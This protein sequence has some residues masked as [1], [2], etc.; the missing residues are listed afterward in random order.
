MNRLARFLLALFVA[1]PLLSLYSNP[2]WER[3]AQAQIQNA[4][5]CNAA[6]PYDAA[7]NGSTQLVTAKQFGATYVCGFSMWSGGVNTVK[8][9]YGTGT[10]CATGE[11]A[12]TPAYSFTAQTGVQ[13]ESAVFRGLFAPEG[14]NLCIK[15]SAAVAVQANVF[16]LQR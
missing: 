8:F 4:I 12:I 14:K 10:A 13:D 7:T 11:T 1:V 2:P 16:Y 9:V 3:N 6:A 15:T 5:T